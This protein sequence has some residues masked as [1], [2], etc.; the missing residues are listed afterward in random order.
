MFLRSRHLDHERFLLDNHEF[1]LVSR[2][3]QLLSDCAD[4]R[5]ETKKNCKTMGDVRRLEEDPSPRFDLFGAIAG[6][7]KSIMEMSR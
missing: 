3:I 7:S 5:E 2:V 4:K 6:A 1:L